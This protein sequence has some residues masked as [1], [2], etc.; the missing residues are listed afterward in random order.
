MD[1]GYTF[2]YGR[3]FLGKRLERYL[4]VHQVKADLFGRI[5][6]RR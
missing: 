5:K 3:V 2:R 1:P 4:D 6:A